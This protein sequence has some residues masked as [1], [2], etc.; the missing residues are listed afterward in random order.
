[1]DYKPDFKLREGPGAYSIVGFHD[2]GRVAFGTTGS[3]FVS[4]AFLGE[5]FGYGCVYLIVEGDNLQKMLSGHKLFREW[6]GHNFMILS[7]LIFLPTLWLRNLS[8]LSYFSLLG[9]TSAGFLWISV[10]VSGFDGGF[11]FHDLGLG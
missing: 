11:A 7:L 3:L 5:T 1:M 6:D 2:L 8:L 10:I 4:A 9:A